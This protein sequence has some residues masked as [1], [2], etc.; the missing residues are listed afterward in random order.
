MLLGLFRGKKTQAM[1]N[2]PLEVSRT[3]PDDF[4]APQTSEKL[5][6]TVRCQ[7]LLKVI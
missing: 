2:P 4:I 7:Q 3:V 6:S 5:L 1:S